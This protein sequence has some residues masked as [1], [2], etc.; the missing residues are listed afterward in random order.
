M[1]VTEGSAD[2]T[3]PFYFVDDVGGTA[4]GEPTTGLLF[5]DIE[6]GGSASYQRQGAARV[7]FALITLAS[8]SAGH[9]DG[10]FILVDDTEMPGTYRC[11]IPDAAV[12]AGVDFVIIYLRAAGAKNTITRPLKIDL[13]SVDLRDAVRGGMTSLPNAAADANNGIVTGDGTATITAGVGGRIAV[14]AEAVSG[15]V[16]AADNLESACDN[17]SATRGLTGTAVPAVAADGVGG[18]PIS[19]AGGLD[20]DALA[21]TADVTT[22]HS[23]TDALLG[24]I[25]A[26]SSGFSANASGVTVTTGTPTNA[27]TDTFS[28]GTIHILTA[29]GGVTLF[30]YDFDLSTFIG[31]ATEFIWDGYV[32]ANGDTVDI[33]YF[34][35][36]TSTY[37]TLQTL[38]GANGTTI[39]ERAFDVPIG[40]TGTGANFGLVKLR[41][42]SSS[43]TNIGTDRVRCV[44]NIAPGGI[45]NGTTITLDSTQTNKVYDG[46]NWTLVLAGQDISGSFFHGA[47]VSGVSSGSSL[48]TFEDCRFNACT[49]PPGTYRRCGF[50][51]SDGLFTAASAGEYVFVDC[52]SLVEGMGTPD[53]TF[54]GNG[55]STGINNRAWKGGAS[56]TLDAD[57]TLSH[58]VLA[59]GTQTITTGGAS[60]ELRGTFRAANIVLG[61]AT[62]ETVQIVGVTGPVTITGSPTAATVNVYGVTSSV[63]LSLAGTTIN[64]LSVS[65]TDIE[66]ILVDT[67]VIGVAGAGLTAI[68]LPNQTMDI[69]GNLSGSV[70]SVTGAVGSVTGA[71]GSV[72]AD[73]TTDAAS[74]TASKADVSAL[75]L[76]ATVAALENVSAAEVNAEVV[77]ALATDTYAEPGQGTPGAT[78]SLAA[79]IG[80]LYK[81]WRNKSTQTATEYDLYNDDTTTVDQKATVSDNATTAT[82]GEISTG[83]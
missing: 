11:D 73:V 77:D 55:A 6:T 25:S 68:N 7:D 28:A 46:E 74:R 38:S 18:L 35:W 59:G 36:P 52:Y 19:D 3:V 76:E 69:T 42:T 20:M 13:T 5:S 37:L 12:A 47:N 63:T 65:Q 54:I 29:A 17:Y 83:P 51:L 56:Q 22:A 23:T 31:T 62:S 14:D 9:A 75:A 58:E 26:G 4:P 32:Q 27:Y 79:K 70:G 72:T 61:T 39:I 41:F 1:I 81:A 30:E 49:L 44:F 40:A 2:V 50:G 21:L 53:F 64:D 16:V 60:V 15:D 80:Y 10:G 71:V 78:I 45:N 43:T 66:A 34:N 24:S 57:C 33:Q 48:V 67:A 82:K 8:A